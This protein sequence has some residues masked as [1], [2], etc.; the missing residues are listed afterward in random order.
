M[1]EERLTKGHHITRPH[2]TKGFKTLFCVDRKEALHRCVDVANSVH[3]AHSVPEVLRLAA[4]V[5][6][7][8]RLRAFFAARATGK[9]ASGGGRD[10]PNYQSGASE[11]CVGSTPNAGKRNVRSSSSGFEIP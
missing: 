2:N 8:A 10:F 4:P 9:S 5:L 1:R 11:L 3:S 7:S 6:L